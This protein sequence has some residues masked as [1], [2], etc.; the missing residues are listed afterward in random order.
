MHSLIM[1]NHKYLTS[2]E[3]FL[4]V[5]WLLLQIFGCIMINSWEDWFNHGEIDG[6]LCDTKYIVIPYWFQK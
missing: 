3:K 4:D 6:D 5:E 2:A 1:N